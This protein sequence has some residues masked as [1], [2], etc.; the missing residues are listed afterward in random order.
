MDYLF[1]HGNDMEM[2]MVMRININL[3]IIKPYLNVSS[4]ANLVAE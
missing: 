3:L 1:K 4:D 2:K